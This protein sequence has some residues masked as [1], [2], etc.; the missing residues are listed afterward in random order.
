MNIIG[1]LVVAGCVAGAGI[2]LLVGELVP[3]APR[4]GP[5]LRRLNPPPPAPATEA[6]AASAQGTFGAWLLRRMP[7][8]LP[9]TDLALLGQAPEQ[10]LINKVSYAFAGLLFPVVVLGGWTLLGLSVPLVLPGVVGVVLAA[11]LWFWPDFSLHS[12][13]ARARI[14]FSYATA[15]FLELVALRMASNRDTAQAL[16]D[17]A[18]IGRGWA[19]VRLQEA[20]LR[21]RTEKSS[22]WQALEDMGQHLKLPVLTDLA[23]I[24]RLSEQDGAAVYDTLRGRARSLRTELLA[25]DATEANRDSEKLSAPGALLCVLA[26]FLIAFPAVLNM[27]RL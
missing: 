9:R 14:E 26:M 1:V 4:L 21:A 23:D 7:L 15:A 17:A 25:T 12:D 5:A 8:T 3:A 13:A 19:F 16:E 27:F 20:L 22:P 24:M 2:A 6:Q 10:F 18:L 11:V